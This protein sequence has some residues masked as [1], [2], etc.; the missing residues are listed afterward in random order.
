M[1]VYM[2]VNAF[3]ENFQMRIVTLVFLKKMF[4]S[5]THLFESQLHRQKETYLYCYFSE[6]LFLIYIS[7]DKEAQKC[8][9][10]LPFNI[11]SLNS[12]LINLC[13]L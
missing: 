9:C 11:N 10:S 6:N 8:F 12:T 2:Y 5:Y 13:S 7:P 4:S 3:K 1:C